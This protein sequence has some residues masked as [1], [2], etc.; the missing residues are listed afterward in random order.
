MFKRINCK[1]F[2][3][4]ALSLMMMLTM[5]PVVEANAAT[6]SEYAAGCWAYAYANTTVYA[7]P[8]LTGTTVGSIGPSE[9]VTVLKVETNSSGVTVYYINYSAP[10]TAKQGYVRWNQV[11]VDG[12]DTCPGIVAR[13]AT[14]YYD[15]NKTSV[16]GSVSSGEI[17]SLLSS[18]NNL[19]YIEYNVTANG[20]RKRGYIDTSA[21]TRCGNKTL[22][23]FWRNTDEPSVSFFQNGCGTTYNVYQVPNPNI[24]TFA[25]INATTQITIYQ[26]TNINGLNFSYVIGI[27]NRPGSATYGQKISGYILR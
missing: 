8:S 23:D 12:N 2:L 20:G 7:N 5:F 24:E 19:F 16:A 13:N 26:I 14:V 1:R 4:L 18:S 3:T 15:S 25:T 11:C 6:A 17:V 9:G 10:G 22:N 21:V 27:D